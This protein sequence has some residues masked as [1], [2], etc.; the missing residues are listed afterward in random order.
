[1]VAPTASRNNDSESDF[2]SIVVVATTII[3][4][5]FAEVCCSLV[6]DVADRVD[7]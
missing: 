1:M 4:F 3:A 2:G 6:T 7:N 5:V